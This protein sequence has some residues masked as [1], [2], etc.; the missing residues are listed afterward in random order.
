MW[1]KT[2]IS[3]YF[4]IYRHKTGAQESFRS[5]WQWLLCLQASFWICLGFHLLDLFS[6]L[7]SWPNCCIFYTDMLSSS[8]IPIFCLATVP[9][10][11]TR[12]FLMSPPNVPCPFCIGHIREW[13]KSWPS[14]VQGNWDTALGSY[15][16]CLL[17]LTHWA[18][19]GSA[20]APKHLV[21]RMSG[22]SVCK[23][24]MCKVET[25]TTPGNVI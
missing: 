21:M 15:L 25:F 7:P 10:P 13:A 20:S 19:R 16:T 4:T 9:R 6:V 17:T 22:L 12:W 5:T 3:F 8:L 23:V 18:W 2:T 11:E 24:T 14:S 1:V